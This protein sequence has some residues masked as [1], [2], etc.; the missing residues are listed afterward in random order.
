[1]TNKIDYSNWDHI[2]DKYHSTYH[3]LQRLIISDFTNRKSGDFYTWE[4]HYYDGGALSGL[5]F[6]NKQ[7]CWLH[8]IDEVSYHRI[9]LIWKLSNENYQEIKY[10]HGLNLEIDDILYY[11]NDNDIFG[12]Y[13]C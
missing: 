11:P 5:C 3:N 2:Y 4:Y 13:V 8:Y 10:C 1:M 12:Y 6:Y 7:P 9:F